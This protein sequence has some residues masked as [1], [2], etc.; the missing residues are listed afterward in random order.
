M[1]ARS[2]PSS[3]RG[4]GGGGGIGEVGPD[5]RVEGSEK[6]EGILERLDETEQQCGWWDGRFLGVRSHQLTFRWWNSP[7]LGAGGWGALL[8]PASW[9]PFN[10][11]GFSSSQWRCHDHVPGPA[12][13]CHSQLWAWKQP[14][15]H[16]QIQITAPLWC[17]VVLSA[18]GA[19]GPIISCQWCKPVRQAALPLELCQADA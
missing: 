2:G 14:C 1:T 16:R 7:L 11:S 4:G 17:G 5:Q 9:N 6:K 8:P 15:S 13:Y 3:R 19:E 10:M 12:G 18:P